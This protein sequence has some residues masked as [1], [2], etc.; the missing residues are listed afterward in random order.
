MNSH[1]SIARQAL[2]LATIPA[3]VS[4]VASPT[5]PG[6]AAAIVVEPSRLVAALPDSALVEAHLAINP[7]NP[8]HMLIATMVGVAG[9]GQDG[10]YTDCTGFVTTDAGAQWRRFAIPNG[11]KLGCAD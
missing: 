5:K 8:R 9:A 7:S 6:P 2:L 3:C 10:T 4:T 11:G 1:I